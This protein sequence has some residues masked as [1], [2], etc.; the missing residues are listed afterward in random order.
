MVK[1]LALVA[2]VALMLGLVLGTPSKTCATELL[3]GNFETGLDGWVANASVSPKSFVQVN[4]KGATLGSKA[5]MVIPNR[6]G[7]TTAATLKFQDFYKS[8]AATLNMVK[9][10]WTVSKTLE[11]D[12]TIDPTNWLYTTFVFNPP[13]GS[14]SVS[15]VSNTT[16]AG[17]VT[18]PILSGPGTWSPTT[19]SKTQTQHLVF[20]LAALNDTLR[21]A[22]GPGDVFELALVV[23]STGYPIGGT[24]YMDNLKLAGIPTIMWVAFSG[25]DNTPSAGAAGAGFAVAPDKGYTDLLGNAGYNVVRYVQTGTPDVNQVNKADLVI[26]SRSVASTSFQN[27]AATT[28]NTG[29]TAPTIIMSGY[30]S[31]KARLGYNTGSTI[32]D[33][34]GDIKLTATDPNNPIFAGITLTA[35]DM[36]NVFAGIV[37][38]PDGKTLARGISVVTEPFNADG[39]LLAKISAASAATGPAGA[40]MIGEWQA[41]AK[42]THDGGVGTDVLAGRRLVFLSGSREANGVN[43][44]TAGQYDLT[45]DG[46]KIFLNAVDYMLTP[47]PA[48]VATN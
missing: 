9:A 29:V 18:L 13:A 10:K 15:L 37:T 22:G 3:L 23:N 12:I 25:A 40:P 6:P 7:K 21:A 26:V 35:G 31:R 5:L 42:V 14:V 4:T 19:L 1:Q 34:T 41:G 24:V 8:D 20:D 39:K 43:S 32:P 16:A 48:P 44:E 47:P 28:W 46:A 36:N 2:S 27:A 17:Q 33:I 45:A 38:Y 11:V 30:L